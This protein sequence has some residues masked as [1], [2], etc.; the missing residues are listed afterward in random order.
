MCECA[1]VCLCACT[2]QLVKK[3]ITYPERVRMICAQS[4]SNWHVMGNGSKETGQAY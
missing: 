2:T 4:D 3:G 1:C